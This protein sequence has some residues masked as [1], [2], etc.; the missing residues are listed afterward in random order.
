MTLGCREFISPKKKCK[1]IK[2][3]RF[4]AF[5]SSF[6]PQTVVLGGWVS[7]LVGV[8][9]TFLDLPWVVVYRFGPYLV[10]MTLGG[11]EFSHHGGKFFGVEINC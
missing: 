4:R 3:E 11:R 5:L 6:W 2:I 9:F 10:W 1:K 8:F 7:F